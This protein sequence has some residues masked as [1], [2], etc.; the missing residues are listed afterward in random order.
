MRCKDTTHAIISFVDY[1]INSLENNKLT[2][3]IFIDIS[4]T[5]DTIDHN[6]LLSKLCNNG[7]R[8][9]TLNWFRNYVSNRYQF[10]SKNNTTSSFLRIEFGVPKGLI[11]GPILLLH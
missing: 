6:I 11:F 1:L 2:C 4:K 3:G 5:F 9:D 7:I 8:G 10:V